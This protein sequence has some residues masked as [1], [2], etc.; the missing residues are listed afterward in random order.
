MLEVRGYSTG[1]FLIIQLSCETAVDQK[2]RMP[3][4]SRRQEEIVSGAETK[5]MQDAEKIAGFFMG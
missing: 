1:Q 5:P 3:V 2:N 4:M